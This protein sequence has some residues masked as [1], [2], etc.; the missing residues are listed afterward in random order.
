MKYYKKSEELTTNIWNVSRLDPECQKT[1]TI[2]CSESS[3]GL[4]LSPVL[5]TLKADSQT[6]EDSSKSG[7]GLVA[8]QTGQSLTSYT[9]FCKSKQNLYQDM[10][11]NRLCKSLEFSCGMESRSHRLN[12]SSNFDNLG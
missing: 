12:I 7:H 11:A 4:D 5:L 9:P 10:E 3:G 6:F 8:L 2:A 1:L